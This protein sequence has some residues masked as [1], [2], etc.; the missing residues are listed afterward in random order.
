MPSNAAENFGEA[1]VVLRAR[2]DVLHQDLVVAEQMIAASTDRVHQAQIETLKQVVVVQKQSDDGSLVGTAIKAYGAWRLLKLT[3]AGVGLGL[4]ALPAILVAIKVAAIAAATAGV[5]LLLT[6][7]GYL[8][9]QIKQVGTTA[10]DALAA[11]KA[12]DGS[13]QKADEFADSLR[14]IPLIG[15]LMS[16]VFIAATQDW[17]VLAAKIRDGRVEVNL[18]A[19][20]V[21][22]MVQGLS[23]GFAP[24][25]VKDIKEANK[26]MD[27]LEARMAARR[28]ASAAAGGD[29]GDRARV[30]ERNAQLEGLTGVN[31][32]RM[33][34]KFRAEDTAR[35]YEERRRAVNSW[36]STELE[37]I[38]KAREEGKLS[39]KDALAEEKD[40]RRIAGN[41]ERIINVQERGERNSNADLAR[42]REQAAGEQAFT[43]RFNRLTAERAAGDAA[44]LRAGGDEFG[45]QRREMEGQRDIEVR[46]AKLTYDDAIVAAVKAK[47]DALF[48]DL[49]R[50]QRES[51][52]RQN[53]RIDDALDG[54]MPDPAEMAEREQERQRENADLQGQIEVERLRATGDERAIRTQEI[55]LR[56]QRQIEQLRAEGNEDGAK[57]AE[58]LR[59]MEVANLK[60]EG[61]ARATEFEQ[62]SRSRFVGGAGDPDQ[63]IQ[64]DQ[65]AVLK[66]IRTNTA[67]PPLAVAS[68]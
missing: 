53:D 28:Q 14:Q 66:D 58:K 21:N 61:S 5:G 22:L 4:K 54:V 13:K 26:E 46:D 3:V 45:A 24:D 20:A 38:R 12:L 9:T 52:D 18:L 44:K 6:L 2:L 36:L 59:D 42:Q 67:T 31:R 37:A 64:R 55:I 1:D 50:R 25:F 27:L 11:F 43:D 57:L 15:R 17:G 40:R 48:A 19:K 8:I 39:A 16:T 32:I 68:A 7:Q 30:A 41:R 56:R 51:A 33:E 10:R 34:E 60:I 29:G 35:Y 65:L 49:E 63:K 62:V 23:F 47:W